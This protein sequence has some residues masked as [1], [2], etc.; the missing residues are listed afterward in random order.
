MTEDP[1]Q[2]LPHHHLEPR[3]PGVAAA[4]PRSAARGRRAR[5]AARPCR[6]PRPRGP[7]RSQAADQ[8]RGQIRSRMT[9]AAHGDQVI[10]LATALGKAELVDEREILEVTGLGP[11]AA[12]VV[13]A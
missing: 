3:A 11:P 9:V 4:L 5:P 6:G 8:A 7:S 10:A 2:L 1:A 13:G 12:R